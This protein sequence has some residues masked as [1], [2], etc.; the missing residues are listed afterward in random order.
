MAQ[1]GLKGADADVYDYLKS[2]DFKT[3]FSSVSDLMHEGMPPEHL[4]V[5][6]QLMANFD[7]AEHYRETANSNAEHGEFAKVIQILKEDAQNQQ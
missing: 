5:L 2:D 6:E 4:K 7:M 1:R 3:T